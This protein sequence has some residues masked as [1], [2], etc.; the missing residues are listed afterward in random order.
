MT[1]LKIHY[2]QHVD[3]EGPG[4][5]EQWAIEKGHKLSATKL[6]LNESF[7]ELAAID[8]LVIMGGPMSVND[9]KSINWIDSEK[10]FISKA[11]KAGKIV[12]GICLGAQLIVSVLGAAVYANTHKEIGWFPVYNP[13]NTPNLLFQ[14]KNLPV[15]HWHGETFDLPVGA[16]LL[17]S[18]EGCTNQ[19]FLYGNTV[20]GL[21]FHFEVTP[22]T[23]QQMLTFGKEDIDG[24][25]YTQPAEY[26]L[27]QQSL[28]AE[29]NRRM[30]TI[31][32]HF[33]SL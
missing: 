21:Q 4:C 19:A 24:S 22:D 32:N 20:L 7:P 23:L 8:W 25:R 30:Y 26:I 15:F 18:S 28:I 6:Y 27:E 33:E 13:D 12:I 1:P 2:L 11:I 29:S 10:E 3:F 9:S 17:A 31:L 14:E 16:M 5:I